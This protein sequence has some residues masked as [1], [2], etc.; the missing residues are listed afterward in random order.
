MKQDDAKQCPAGALHE[1]IEEA[2]EMAAKLDMAYTV[3]YLSLAN[4][5]SRLE[6]VEDV[7]SGLRS[8]ELLP[9]ASMVN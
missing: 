3:E 7:N 9:H 2:L 6:R 1:K 8:D 4:A 5:A